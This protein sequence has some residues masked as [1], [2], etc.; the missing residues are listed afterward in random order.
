[1]A[2][3]SST[4]TH[5]TPIHPARTAAAVLLAAA[6]LGTGAAAAT[7]APSTQADPTGQT[8]RTP[9]E[10]QVLPD[11]DGWASADG[12]TTGGAAAAADRVYDVDFRA[13]LL[14]ALEAGDDEKI[15]RVH[16]VIDASEDAGGAPQTCD[17][18]AGG[19]GYSL[20]AYLAAYDPA[21]W[22]WEEDPAGPQEEARQAAASHQQDYIRWDIPSNTTLVGADPDSGITGAALRING[23]HNVIVRNLTISDSKDC[24]PAW[25]PTDGDTG[26]W[27][28][29][30]DLLQVINGSTN[31]W[32]DHSTFTDAPNFDDELPEYFGRPFQMHDGAVDVTNGSN[33]V[34][35]SYNRFEDHDKLMLIGSTDSPTRGDP[36]KLKVTLHHNVFEDIGQRAPRVRYGQV[37]VYN[38]HFVSTDDAPVEYSYLF[39]AGA[40]SH[41]HVTDNAIEGVEASSVIKNWRGTGIYTANNLVDGERTDL[42]AA[43]NAS[44]DASQQLAVDTSWTPELRTTVHAPQALPA[45]LERTAGPILTAGSPEGD[46]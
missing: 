5:G 12:G 4:A 31:V 1:M 29:E 35:M 30:Y 34:T 13:E 43:H 41:L 38:N 20:E 18:Y 42:L 37:D 24:F 22:G 9:L 10:R 2:R 14:A 28:S 19:T 26:S 16:G 44:V 21:V 23:E 36:G 3:R 40:E 33:Y 25:D 17:A 11:G 39:G 8:A 32:I 15:I 45:L 46:R 27:N 6:L 7:G